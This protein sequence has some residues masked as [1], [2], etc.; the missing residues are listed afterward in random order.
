MQDGCIL[1]GFPWWVLISR[2]DFVNL[3]IIGVLFAHVC[4]ACV[5]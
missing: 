4:R 1:C 5:V 2:L 3:V